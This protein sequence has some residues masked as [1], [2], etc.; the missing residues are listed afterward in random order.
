MTYL[1]HWLLPSIRAFFQVAAPVLHTYG[2]WALAFVLFLENGGILM[3]PGEAV[4]VSAGVLAGQGVFSPYLAAPLAV[5]AAFAGSQTAFAGGQRL[6]HKFLLR[7]GPKIWI[8]P[9]RLAGVHRFFEKYGVFA[10]LLGR[11][12]VPL[13]QLQG[14]AA[15]SSEMPALPFLAANLVGAV[16]W[17]GA[18]G[19]AGFELS[20]AMGRVS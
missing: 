7:W 20:S 12:V 18:W 4:V 9:A 11:F 10:V 1:L 14:W 17:V 8:T 3:A 19:G 2:L 5:L 16:L 15:G 13:R 6:G